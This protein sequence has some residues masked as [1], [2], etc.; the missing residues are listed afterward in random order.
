MVELYTTAY[1]R[2]SSKNLGEAA[3]QELK[4]EEREA[5]AKKWISKFENSSVWHAPCSRAILLS[6]RQVDWRFGRGCA[7]ACTPCC[8]ASTWP[9]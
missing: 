4:F 8:S 9:R 7:P 3:L 2:M 6:A 1:L 5:A